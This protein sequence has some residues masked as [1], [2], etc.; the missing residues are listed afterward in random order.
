MLTKFHLLQTATAIGMA[1]GAFSA[2]VVQVQANPSIPSVQL[3]PNNTAKPI[4]YGRS[5]A[6]GTKIE[7]VSGAAEIALAEH[8]VA[9]GAKFYGAYWCSHC[10]KQKSLFG[11][12]ASAKL[13]YVECAADGDNSQRELCRTKNIKMFPTWIVNGKFYPG[14]KDLKEIAALTGYSGPSNFQYKK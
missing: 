10:Q 4:R 11:A 2:P 8:L 9:S 12:T 5:I 14:T 1:I 13:P 7:T 6:L 3:T